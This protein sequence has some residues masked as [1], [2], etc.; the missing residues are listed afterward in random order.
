MWLVAKIKKSELSLFKAE[1]VKK[2]SS[3]VKFY[4]PKIQYQKFIKNKINKYDKFV[5]ENYIFCYHETFNQAKIISN[6]RFLKGLEYFLAGHC[7]NQKEIISFI[8][9]CKSFEDRKGYLSQAFFKDIVN[10]KAQFITGPF[11]NMI[12]EIIEKQKNK[13]DW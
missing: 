5:L 2:I 10:R 12:F 13:F 8:N 6:I 11:A 7:E 9:Y 3:E 1:L 4:S